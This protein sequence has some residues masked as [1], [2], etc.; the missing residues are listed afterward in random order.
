[1]PVVWGVGVIRSRLFAALLL[2]LAVCVAYANALWGVFQFDDYN[3]IVSNPRV[4]SWAAWWADTGHG[5]RPLLKLTYTL[6]WT[7]GLGETGFHLTNVF[8]HLCNVYLVWVLSR[9][10]VARHAQLP[11]TLSIAR[12]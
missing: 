12:P 2:L 1:M 10:F 11:C 6:D 3:V 4:H 9:Y 8:I 5:I 7:L